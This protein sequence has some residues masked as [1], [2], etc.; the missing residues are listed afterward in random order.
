[1]PKSK[2]PDRILQTTLWIIELR[3]DKGTFTILRDGSVIGGI[4]FQPATWQD[5]LSFAAGW[6][7]SKAANFAGIDE[8]LSEDEPLPTVPDSG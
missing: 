3:G 8:M 6:P 1:M 4:T 2:K 5:L 7:P